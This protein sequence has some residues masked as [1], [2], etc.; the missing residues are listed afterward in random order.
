MHDSQ[1]S[2]SYPRTSSEWNSFAIDETPSYIINHEIFPDRTFAQLVQTAFSP[3]IAVLATYDADKLAYHKGFTQGF[4]ELLRPFGDE[5]REKIV[6]HDMQGSTRTL[7]NFALHFV[8]FDAYDMSVRTKGKEN[9]FRATVASKH[10][11]LVLTTPLSDYRFGTNSKDVE[12]WLWYL[13]YF[14]H[15]DISGKSALLYTQQFLAGQPLVPF[16][17]FNYPVLNLFVVSSH[18]T[19]PV[20]A[21]R[22]LIQS[23]KYADC[24]TFLTPDATPRYVFV[25]DEDKHDLEL[26]IAI[27]DTMK[28]S[29]GDNGFF[30]RLH[31]QK[32]TLDYESA[33]PCPRP[34][35]LSAQ[36]HLKLL[37]ASEKT[38]FC[39][40]QSDVQAIQRFVTN[41][42]TLS[43][44][45]HMER[46]VKKW[47]DQYASTRR[48]FTGKLLFASKKYFSPSGSGIA[49]NFRHA[50]HTYK[51]NSTE[52]FMRRL[53][54]FSF[55]LGDWT[56]AISVYEALIR[57]YNNDQ[58][59]LYLA[60]AQEIVSI[61]RSFSP[62][63]RVRNSEKS[64][65]QTLQTYMSH[66]TRGVP[67]SHFHA[68]RAFLLLG[69]LFGSKTEVDIDNSANW[70][71][72]LLFFRR[73]GPLGQAI[74]FQRIANLY[75][76]T[77]EKAVSASQGA[78]TAGTHRSRIRK[79]AFWSLL[80]AEFWCKCR[81]P[82]L[83]T[84][85]F[86]QS[87]GTYD[88]IRWTSINKS[89]YN[90][91]KEIDRL[92]KRYTHSDP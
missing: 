38:P 35:W 4:W 91:S 30:L 27:F 25:H 40:F 18:N 76:E 41:F 56:H 31:S 22:V 57:Q 59:H 71:T 24:P 52:F 33:V 39:I 21:L 50:S 78:V 64:T 5:I 47:D 42:S 84:P 20:D 15:Q 54:D 46:C 88:Q 69:Q 17:T 87:Q 68:A 72:S 89:V 73:L 55:M 7:N 81:L 29:F 19:S 66:Y 65:L 58:A 9:S 44:I 63:D 86:S 14:R 45:P 85:L 6:A 34:Q 8:P 70:C 10:P 26:S 3:R 16:E 1:S 53:A 82:E 80:A 61:A 83:A 74:M 49:S 92:Q 62:E 60:A 11:N 48:G 23:T 28:R 77:C 2:G 36:E 75:Q 12:Q 32:A 43:V 37:Q 90:V 51:R 13:A 79:A 67:N